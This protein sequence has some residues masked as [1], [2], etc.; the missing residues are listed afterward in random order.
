[1][2]PNA[3]NIV[4]LIQSLFLAAILCT[5]CASA[6]K[7]NIDYMPYM[8]C[9]QQRIKLHWHPERFP[10]T[11]RCI[12]LF[13]IHRDGSISDLKFAEQTTIQ[14][15]NRSTMN[16]VQASA[17]FDPLPAGSDDDVDIKFTFDYNIFHDLDKLR[18]IRIKDCEEALAQKET[19][20]GPEHPAA[21]IAIRNLADEVSNQGKYE[22]AEPM[23]KR[24]IA[25]QEKHIPATEKELAITLTNFGE[26]YYLQKKYAD[27]EPLYK[28]GLSINEKFPTNNPSLQADLEHYAKLLY[29]TNRTTQANELYDRLKELRSQKQK[30]HEH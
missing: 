10:A 26:L 13:K 29:V 9:V 20:F 14:S 23:Y 8:R 2:N 25:I 5:T 27:A 7:S 16:A 30:A 28:H 17:P 4:N 21:A 12:V 19:Q 3:P 18:A 1:M 15:L 22:K 11:L 6:K 24:A